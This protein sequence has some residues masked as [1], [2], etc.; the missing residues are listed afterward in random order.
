M[1][2]EADAHDVVLGRID[3]AV[4]VLTG[5][6]DLDE[7]WR[8]ERDGWT[9]KARGVWLDHLL[10]LRLEITAGGGPTLDHDADHLVRE[11]DHWGITFHGEAT[12]PFR[13]VTAAVADVQAALRP[14]AGHRTTQ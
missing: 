6:S 14:L 2:D 13:S 7:K 8:P 11:L 9:A 10:A 1:S 4:S 5:L 12:E 3:Q